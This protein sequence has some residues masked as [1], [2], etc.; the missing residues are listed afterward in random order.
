MGG[1]E[2][3]FPTA[4][5]CPELRPKLGHQLSCNPRAKIER[6]FG[7]ASAPGRK[8][9]GPLSPA[10]E[11]ARAGL[12]SDFYL[13]LPAGCPQPQPSTLEAPSS[14]SQAWVTDLRAG[15]GREQEAPGT[16][17]TPTRLF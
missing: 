8:G 12:S 11:D 5:S 7:S 2:V 13:P 17:S 1:Q 4:D 16:P 9:T 6:S 14:F 10:S 3:R 15:R